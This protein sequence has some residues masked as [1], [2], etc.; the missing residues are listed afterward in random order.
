VPVVSGATRWAMLVLAGCLYFISYFH[1][2]APSVMATDLMAAFT[3]TATVLGTLSA[4]YPY[5]FAVMGI[6]A[7]TLADTLGPRR[8]LALGA[9][10]MAVGATVFG[11]AP[12]FGVAY[13]G[14]LLVGLGASVILISSLRLAA[15]WFSGDEFALASGLVLT[16]GNLGGLA[17]AVPLA[18]SVE[19]IGWRASFLVIA[20][21][22]LSLGVVALLAV[23]DAPGGGGPRRTAGPG[24]GARRREALAPA[25]GAAGAGA[26]RTTADADGGALRGGS[27]ASLAAALR[28]IPGIVANPRTWPP[29]L[30][31][32]GVNGTLL[33]LLGLWGVPYLV[34]VHGYT[35][36]EASASLSFGTLGIVVAAPLVGRLSDRWLRRRR[37]PFAVS[38]ALFA[39]SWA[40]LLLVS[41]P[42]TPGWT[43]TLVFFGLGASACG[44]FV[45]LWSCVRE[46]NDPARVGVALGFSNTPIFVTFALLQWLT[47]VVL[48]LGWAGAVAGG[49]R[50]YPLA[51]YQEMFALCLGLAVVATVLACFVTETYCANVWPATGRTRPA[52]PGRR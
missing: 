2:I 15:A 12:R 35:R 7:G 37:L 4:V 47:G 30:A 32:A 49:R 16:F 44:A 43:L 51:A 6:P 28:A 41:R 23:R 1:R 3:I 14:R 20:A 24:S 38:T 46:V 19:R 29:V 34:D 31:T 27:D 11:L 18:V 8:T 9:A 5:V 17:A 39:L 22:T 42:G 33:T 21:V 40:G 10:T 36:V 50:V 48:D 26:A 52:A 13:T 45:L 25:V